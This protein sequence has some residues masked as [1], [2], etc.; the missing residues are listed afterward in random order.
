MIYIY[1]ICSELCVISRV[2]SCFSTAAA[3]WYIIIIN[4]YMHM[5]GRGLLSPEVE[6]YIDVD[7]VLPD[8]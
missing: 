5:S 6:P 8:V 2:F 7:H 4:Y 3:G 1:Y